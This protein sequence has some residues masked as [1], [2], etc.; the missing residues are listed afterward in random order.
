MFGTVMPPCTTANTDSQNDLRC[1][2][3]L[4]V[5]LYRQIKS[6]PRLLSLSFSH[7]WQELNYRMDKMGSSPCSGLHKK[8]TR[9]FALYAYSHFSNPI[10][11][12]FF[13]FVKWTISCC[14]FIF[15][16]LQLYYTASLALLSSVCPSLCL[17]V[18]LS[19]CNGCT[20]AKG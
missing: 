18:C 1:L 20:V 16:T 7:S 12:F 3:V 11:M 9:N 19:V 10:E 6:P 13:I 17:S 14:R 8:E 5:N 15:D 2:H 4:R